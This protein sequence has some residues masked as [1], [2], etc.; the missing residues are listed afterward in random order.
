MSCFTDYFFVFAT[1]CLTVSKE[2][3][4][5]INS[6]HREACYRKESAQ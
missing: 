5:G 6:V 2:G 1:W 3:Q 4:G